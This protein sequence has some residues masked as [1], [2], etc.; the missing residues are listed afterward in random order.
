MKNIDFIPHE[1]I[2]FNSTYND[3]GTVMFGVPFDGTTSNK[4]GTRFAG[5]AIR[6][7]S[8]GIE[9][10]SPY[11]DRDLEDLKLCDLGEL[12]LPFGN[13][14]KVLDIVENCTTQIL[15]SGK[16]PVIIGGEHLVTLGAVRAFAKKYPELK[17][18]QFDAHADL[19]DDYLGEKLSHACV[20][21]RVYEILGDGKIFQL[22][23]RSGTR[24][25]FAF[26][27]EHT[28]MNKFAVGNLKNL[29]DRL[30]F[31]PVYVTVDL[32]V[33]DPSEF[34]ATGTPEAGGLRWSELRETL[35]YIAATGVNVVG[36]DINEY[37]PPYDSN[38]TCCALA[39]KTLR[40]MV[41]DFC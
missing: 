20:M 10:Y 24:E 16:F 40:E 32:D 31:D 30:S 9:T 29:I 5:K 39:A 38:N 8:F 14:A 1:F 22:G 19:R 13:P 18:V 25:E 41:L 26:A 33:L 35:A 7:E 34:P 23:I 17:I 28:I 12:D 11:S 27:K 4:A 15:E 21:R 6:G 2:G 36:F 3:A 37:S